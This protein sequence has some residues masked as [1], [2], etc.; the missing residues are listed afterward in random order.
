[1]FVFTWD[2]GELSLACH[3][4]RQ[5]ALAQRAGMRRRCAVPSIHGGPGTHT[6][7][8]AYEH[9]GIY[10]EAAARTV[11]MS[12]AAWIGWASFVQLLATLMDAMKLDSLNIVSL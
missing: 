5:R 11:P 7:P 3:V 12:Y 8:W 6:S 4:G 10:A 9:H 2:H 1:V